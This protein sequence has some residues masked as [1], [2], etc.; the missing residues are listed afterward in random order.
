MRTESQED[1]GAEV[2]S[3]EK[4]AAVLP[5]RSVQQIPFAFTATRIP[6]TARGKVLLGSTFRGKGR[7]A[8]CLTTSAFDIPNKQLAVQAVN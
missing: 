6:P 1:K 3:K 5:P 7:L 4:G 8:G 2:K